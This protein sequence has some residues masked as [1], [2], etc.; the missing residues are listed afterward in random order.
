MRIGGLASGI[1]TDSMI[2]QLMQVERQPLDRFFQR[3]QTIE[4]QRDAYREMNTKLKA[5]EESAF[6]IRLTGAFNTREAVSSNSSAFTASAAST[7]QNGTYEFKVNQVAT[8]TRNISTENISQGSS[9]VSASAKLNDQTA[10]LGENIS[11]YDGDKFTITTFDSAGKRVDKEF[12]IDTSKSLNDLFKQINDAKLGVRAYYDS[13]YDRVVFERTDTGSF[14]PKEGPQPEWQIEF[15]GDTDFLTDVLKI[16]QASEA[17]GTKAEVEFRNPVFGADAEPIIVTQN[18]N[19]VTIG[20]L[21]FNALQTTN[22]FETVTVSSN[23]DQAFDNIKAFVDNYNDTIAQIQISLN[24]PRHRGF[25][26]LT[27]EQRRELSE[28]EADLWDERAKSG[29]LRRDPLLTSILTQ[30]RNDLSTPVQTSGRFNQLSQIGITTTSNFR[31]GGRLEIDEAKLRQ[32]LEDDPSAVHQLFNNVADKSLTDIP[33]AERT[34]DQRNQINNETGLV[35]RIRASI[36]DTMQKVT[37][38]AGNE[39]RTNQQFTLGRELLDVDSQIDRFQRRLADIESR[40][41]AQFSRMEQAV[42]QAN[43]QGAQLMSAFMNF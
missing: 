19:R 15:T 28:R 40:Y 34:A 14:G 32:A 24:E 21:T 18:S 31:D 23:T 3:K 33:R 38:R 36:N 20:G 37:S 27:D 39:N 13:A 25:P 42:N 17:A 1:D 41:W 9:K 4:W 12:T 22:G 10:A 2:R 5:L 43:A 26:P 8:R 16:N 29:L 30:M 11:S 7:V 35:G 6:A